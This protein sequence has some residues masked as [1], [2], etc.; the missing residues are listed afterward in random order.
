M[1][2]ERTV[3]ALVSDVRFGVTY[4][5]LNEAIWSHLDTGLSLI[6]VLFGA[7]AVAGLF[8][9]PTLIAVAGVVLA[10]VSALQLGLS[11]RKRSI[12]FRDARIRFHELQGRAW[13]LELQAL[14]TELERVR[15]SA[16]VGLRALSRPA[17]NI[18]A[19]SLGSSDQYKLTR[20]ESLLQ[21][22]AW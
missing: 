10:L 19:E 7:L 18:V 11:P 6:Q 5:G 8:S 20:P 4:G 22:L 16:P 13:S 2:A 15:A 12:E 17:W 3:A 1:P 21:A 9:G 14:E